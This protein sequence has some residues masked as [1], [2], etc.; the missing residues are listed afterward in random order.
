MRRG[1]GAPRPA[2][3][4][5][6]LQLCCIWPAGSYPSCCWCW[7]STRMEPWKSYM[8]VIHVGSRLFSTPFANAATSTHLESKKATT[9]MQSKMVDKVHS[10]NFKSLLTIIKF[11]KMS[12]VCLM[13]PLPVTFCQGTVNFECVDDVYHDWAFSCSLSPGIRNDALNQLGEWDSGFLQA[14]FIYHRHWPFVSS[15]EYDVYYMWELAL[16]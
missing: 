13:N 10:K 14:G 11:W 2:Q 15:I 12:W 9:T 4:F 7:F 8:A 5:R 6:L 1:W 16:L 3:M